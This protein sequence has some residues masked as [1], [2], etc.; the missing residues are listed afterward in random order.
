MTNILGSTK[1][2]ERGFCYVE[3]KDIYGNDCQL[4]QSSLAIN[5]EPGTS[6]IWLGLTGHRMH[7]DIK[8]TE[9]LICHLQKWIKN[10]IFS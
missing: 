7:L 4:Q 6:A 5:S 8:Q 2:T 3:W 1:C 10:G 9:A